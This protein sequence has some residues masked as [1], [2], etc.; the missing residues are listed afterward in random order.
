MLRLSE[1]GTTVISAFAIMGGVQILAPEDVHVR[2]TG[3]GIMGGFGENPPTQVPSE[4][5]PV[6][7]IR[8]VAFWGGVSVRHMKR[9]KKELGR[10]ASGEIEA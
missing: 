8:G 9:K 1:S 10:G 5:A 3:L 7:Q 4:H 6:V 2:V